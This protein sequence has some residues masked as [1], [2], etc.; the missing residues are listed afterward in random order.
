MSDE[1][2]EPD[3]LAIRCEHCAAGLRVRAKLAGQSA[4]CPN[5]GEP[6]NIPVRPV[7]EFELPTDE[8]ERDWLDESGGYR[9]AVP[10]QHEPDSGIPEPLPSGIRVP[11]PEMGYLERVERVRDDVIETPPK[12]LFFSGVFD[13]PWYP[14]V[15]PRWVYLVLG[16]S[17]ASLIPLLGV[18]FLEGTSGYAA[19]GV[20][21]FAMPQIWITFWS[22]SYM[23]SCGMQI[24][25][26][27]SAG[28]DHITTW[29]D[30]NWREWMWPLLYLAYVAAMVLAVAYGVALACGARS[31]NLVT[32]LAAVEFVLFPICLLSVLETNNIAILF[33]P[34]VLSSL[35]RKPA[36]WI[37]FY[38]LTGSMLVA[39]GGM[40]WYVYRLN[41]LMVVVVNGL[42]Y[43]SMSLIW[44]RLLGRLGWLITHKRGQK[45]RLNTGT[46]RQVPRVTGESA[47]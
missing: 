14:E 16:G 38:A 12:Y 11:A 2:A 37:L 9:L 33:S 15:W 47:T 46:A 35:F 10:L 17:L 25:E 19:V 20:A 31:T 30:P 5:C 8:D 28:S 3:F 42:L 45:R 44:F 21:F 27:T 6:I 24:F 13:F 22:G 32:V 43:A 29:P 39:W 18:A 23:A 1:S 4:T 34:R 41:P 40:I 26:D 7:V 36:G